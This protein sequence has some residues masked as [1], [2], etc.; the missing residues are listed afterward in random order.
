[1]PRA[2]RDRAV[3]GRGW[4]MLHGSKAELA[5]GHALDERRPLLFGEGQHR[6]VRV[7][8]VADQ[9]V[10]GHLRHLDA[11]AA[12]AAL[13]L[14]PLLCLDLVHLLPPFHSA[15]VRQTHAE[16]EVATDDGS[17]SADGP[18]KCPRVGAERRPYLQEIAP[19]K[20]IAGRANEGTRDDGQLAA[21]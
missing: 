2:G 3:N 19:H 16:K 15:T 20:P 8:R 17:S 18:P 14:S 4:R 6:T 21:V 13:A 9:V 10:P 11:R 12:A 1:M 7:L 5:V